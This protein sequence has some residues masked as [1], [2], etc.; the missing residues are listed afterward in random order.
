M[1]SSLRNRIFHPLA[2]F[3]MMLAAGM[4][5]A[6]GGPLGSDSSIPST[7]APVGSGARAAGMANAFV[8]IAD[9]ATAVSW[10]PAGLVQLEEPEFSIVGQYLW[11]RDDI[12][13]W[14]DPEANGEYSFDNFDLNFLSFVYPVPRPI[15]NRNLVLS[16]SYQ[17][18][19]DFTRNLSSELRTVQSALGDLLLRQDTTLDFDQQGS[20]GAVSAAAAYE[21]TN[22]F[23]V[24][25]A[26]NLWRKT[27][28]EESGWEQE[29]LV[30]SR[31]TA[32]SSISSSR[33][34]SK[35]SYE[36]F[37]GENLTLGAMWRMTDKW[38]LGARYET[39]FTGEADYG[40]VDWDL[41]LVP[42]PVQPVVSN[43]A[44]TREQRKIRFPDTL[45]LGI[46]YRRNDRLTLAMDVTRTD[47]ND[48]YVKTRLGDRYSL[49]DGA[50]LRNPF[51]RTD[52][53]P[54]YTVRLGGEYAFIP[55]QRG[56]TL[57][58]LW[59]LRGGLFLEQEP[60]SG[61]SSRNFFAPGDGK[62]D[63]FFGVATGV[64]LLLKQRVN[65]DLSYQY[66]WGSGVNGDL[67]PGVIGFSDDED[68][69]RVMLSTVIYF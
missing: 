55:K 69:H 16:L 62:A 20:L 24:G 65:I 41:R 45:A 2:V 33:G 18:R 32:G 47:W 58:H 68:S 48:L 66:R 44:S 50:D 7:P 43:F 21:I 13:S 37:R 49:V 34:Y 53:D 14:H 19:Y 63:N 26:L 54:T 3:S 28:L 67:N 61:R 59:T 42:N 31:F 1:I 22:T 57:D 51:R 27:F 5:H 52:F 17:K 36:D 46:A 64:G 30:H 4:A 23:S 15:W 25:L 56:E 60:A 38:T 29:T 11:N 12:T 10:N 35:E 8:A 40:A 6:Q 39:A 9:D